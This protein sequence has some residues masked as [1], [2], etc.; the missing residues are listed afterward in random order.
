ME[1]IPWKHVSTG[2]LLISR[3]SN[4]TPANART[5]T[6]GVIGD[7]IKSTNNFNY[8]KNSIINRLFQVAIALVDS[9]P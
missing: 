3:S 5:A 4:E 6:N 8:D 1:N 9:L 2:L 7:A